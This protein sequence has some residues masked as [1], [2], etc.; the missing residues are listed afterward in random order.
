MRPR[1][2]VVSSAVGLLILCASVF[3]GPQTLDYFKL[4]PAVFGSPGVVRGWSSV[5]QPLID[6]A[7]STAKGTVLSYYGC[8]VEVPCDVVDGVGNGEPW[9]EVRFK[10]GQ[11]VRLYNTEY[12]QDNRVN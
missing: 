2:I 5:P 12:F 11:E 3:F 4:R 10:T 9:V 6:K 7:P 1:L 8:K